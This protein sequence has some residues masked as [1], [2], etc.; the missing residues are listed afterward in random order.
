M[1][2]NVLVAI[3]GSAHG[4]R[5]LTEAIEMAQSYRAQLTIVTSVP[6]PS[7]WVVTGGAYAGTIDQ[8]ALLEETEQ[9]YGKILEAAV[10]TVPQD[11]SVTSR[12]RHGRPG[13]QILEQL[14]EGHHDLVVMGSRGRGNVRSLVLGSVSHHVLNATPAAVLIVH[15]EE[16]SPAAS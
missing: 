10:A 8:D 12:L 16:D 11:V 1:F 6:D 15:A 5:A 9:E 7:A 13:D 2:H 4:Q 3:D 14:A